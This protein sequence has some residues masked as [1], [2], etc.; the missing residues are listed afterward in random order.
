VLFLKNTVRSNISAENLKEKKK[1]N[2]CYFATFS[3]L[4]NEER[5]YEQKIRVL[6]NEGKSSSQSVNK[7]RKRKKATVSYDLY[8]YFSS[9]TLS[10]NCVIL[11][12]NSFFCMMSE[13]KLK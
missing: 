7:S 2:L 3:K 13:F 8:S 4:E 9:R 10:P 6:F 11:F 12:I 5:N 1:K